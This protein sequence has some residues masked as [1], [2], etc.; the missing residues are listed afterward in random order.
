MVSPPPIVPAAAAKEK[1]IQQPLASGCAPREGLKEGGEAENIVAGAG[2]SM[3]GRLTEIYSRSN[4]LP[5]FGGI[6]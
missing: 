5:R 1:L 3:G 4:R 2:P 6:K